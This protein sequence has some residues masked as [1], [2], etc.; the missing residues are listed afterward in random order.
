M[1]E[2][3]PETTTTTATDVALPEVAAAAP[4]ETKPEETTEQQL[5]RWKKQA[6]ENEN[7]AKANAKA[8]QELEKLK[9]ANQTDAE[10]IADE[11]A[12][13]RKEADE[14]RAEMARWKAAATHHVSEDYFDLLGTGT[15]EE[16]TARAERVGKL[17][18]AMAELTKL[19]ADMAAAATAAQTPP[20]NQPV[21]SLKPGAAVVPDDSYPSSWFPQLRPVET[22]NQ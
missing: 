22:T 14:A 15:T 21:S 12:T 7:Q 13:A 4:A 3:A 10:R 20:G 6:R 17:E 5:A 18:A 8:A 11:A 16:I 2:S 19:K 9:K 1:S